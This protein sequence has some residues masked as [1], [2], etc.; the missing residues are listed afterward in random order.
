MPNE[1]AATLDGSSATV[2]VHDGAIRISS[3]DWDAEGRIGLSE[4]RLLASPAGDHHAR[5][6]WILEFVPDER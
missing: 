3:E 6:A 1:S 5:E 2:A 4:L